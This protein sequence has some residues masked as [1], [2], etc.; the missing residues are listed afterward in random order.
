MPP[1]IVRTS[2]LEDLQS[3]C[4]V[5][6]RSVSISFREFTPPGCADSETR[7]ERV[8]FWSLYLSDEARRRR[9]WVAEVNSAILGIAQVGD[10]IDGYEFV[11]DISRLYGGNIAVLYALHVDPDHRGRGIGRALIGA[12]YRYMDRSGFDMSVL[13][14]HE[15]NAR[16]R[17]FYEAAGWVHGDTVTNA[18][19]IRIALYAT[20][21]TDAG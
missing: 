4:D 21:L 6:F 9:M 17:A 15:T 18:N 8:E 3:I 2:T 5:S 10:S 16:A 20:T 12:A 1:V 14:T 7:D 13:D 19:G 11:D